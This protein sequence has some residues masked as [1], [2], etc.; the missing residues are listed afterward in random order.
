MEEEES[1]RR[2]EGMVGEAWEGVRRD[3]WGEVEEECSNFKGVVLRGA[4]VVC[5]TKVLRIGNWSKRSEWWSVEIG[6]ID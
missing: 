5:G 6:G 3:E 2:F 4:K 1:R